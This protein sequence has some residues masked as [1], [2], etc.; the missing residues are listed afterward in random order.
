MGRTP[1]ERGAYNPLPP[2]QIGRVSDEHWAEI[3]DAAKRDGKTL[4]AW[5]IEILLKAARRLKK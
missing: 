1:T 2:R 5:A 3:K 4:T